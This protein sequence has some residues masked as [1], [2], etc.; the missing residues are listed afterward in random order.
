MARQSKK[1]W[2]WNHN[3]LPPPTIPRLHFLF[4][5]LFFI[6]THFHFPASGQAVVTGV[7]PSPPRFLP[8]IFIAHRVQQSHCSSIVHRMLPTHALALSAVNLFT[9][10]SPNEFIRVCTRRGSNSR[11]WPIPGSNISWYATWATGH[12]QYQVVFTL[13]IPQHHWHCFTLPPINTGR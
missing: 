5:I 4:F 11:N 9:R 1:L 3:P 2:A 13:V 6:F 8:S 7:I 10:K 12:K